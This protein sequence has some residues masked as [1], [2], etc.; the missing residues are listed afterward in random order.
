MNLPTT[1]DGLALR[2]RPFLRAA[3]GCLLLAGVALSLGRAQTQSDAEYEACKQW[4]MM[5]RPIANATTWPT[6]APAEKSTAFEFGVFGP[7]KL[8]GAFN[9]LKATPIKGRNVRVK[10][11]HDLAEA[12]RCHLVFFS[13]NQQEEFAKLVD[14]LRGTAVLTVGDWSAFDQKGGMLRLGRVSNG[15]GDFGLNRP[16]LKQAQ[17]SMD[18]KMVM[19]LL[20][21]R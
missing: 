5:L 8:V 14:Q 10:P 7:D 21:G 4:A 17:L 6:N 18:D 12:Q 19:F 16:A 15:Q 9:G 11:C 1:I 13:I 3:R 20:T 2:R